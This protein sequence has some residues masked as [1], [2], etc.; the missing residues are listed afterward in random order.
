[1]DLDAIDQRVLGSLLEKERTVPATYPLTLNALRS[2]C[3]QTSGRDPLM[4]L[5]DHEVTAAIDRLK[6]AKLARIVYAGTGARAT[7]YRQV[8]DERLG[9]DDA[10]RAVV[11]VL[12]LRGA[13]TPGEL[14]TRSE[15]LHAFATPDEVEATLAKLAAREEPLVA[16]LDRQPGRRESRWAHLLGPVDVAASAPVA[17]G[18]AAAPPPPP[19]TEGAIA[20]GAEARDRR[21]LATYDRVA[22]AYAD[23]LLDELAHKPLDRWLLERLAAEAG[24]GPVADV[25]CGPGQDTFHLAAAGATVT[26]FDL[27]PAMVE[28]ARRRFPELDFAV[29]DLR[30]LPAAGGGDGGWAVIAAWY[31]LVH[32][33]GSELAG[34]VAALARRLRPGGMLALAVHLGGSVRHLDEFMGAPV[35]ID[36]TLH[37]QD[38]VLAAV[39]SA[40]LVDVEWYRRSPYQGHEVDTERFYVLGRRPAEV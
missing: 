23:E 36:F 11:T 39:R 30:D 7:K 22:T 28:E 38:E 27:S 6:A 33:A 8:L 19:A 14:R 2:A 12:L 37:D 18:R 32:L 15:R 3:N 31:A 16:E 10:E 40:G 24:D 34:A 17:S 1:M 29:A 13:Q 35:S 25:G 20:D 5:A 21:V 4:K 9:L 26:G